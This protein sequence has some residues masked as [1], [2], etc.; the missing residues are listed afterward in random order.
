MRYVY[1]KFFTKLRVCREIENRSFY[2]KLNSIPLS[3][4]KKFF[5]GYFGPLFAGARVLILI[6]PRFPHFYGF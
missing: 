4:Q 6:L 5:C 1:K 3:S 2:A